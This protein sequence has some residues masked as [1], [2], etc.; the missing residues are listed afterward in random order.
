MRKKFYT[1]FF[2]IFSVTFNYAFAANCSRVDSG[3]NYWYSCDGTQVTQTARTI[4]G[5]S[6]TNFT[7]V[8]TT[9]TW[10]FHDGYNNKNIF[11]SIIND[12]L[13]GYD[14]FKAAGSPSS[15]ID[16][17]LIINQGVS[18]SSTSTSQSAIYA[19]KNLPSGSNFILINKGNIFGACGTGGGG[20]SWQSYPG[21]FRTGGNGGN[22]GNAINLFASS[23]I[24]NFGKI[25]SGGGGGGGGGTGGSYTCGGEFGYV[26]WALGGTG[27]N[28]GSCYSGIDDP[29]DSPGA[30]GIGGGC[31]P[32]P[33]SGRP[34]GAGGSSYYGRSGS[35]GLNGIGQNCGS[36]NMYWC[37]YTTYGLG[38]AGG[39]AGLSIKTNSFPTCIGGLQ[40]EVKGSVSGSY[41][42][43]CTIDPGVLKPPS[44]SLYTSPSLV[45]WGSNSTINWTSS[46]SLYCEATND[47]SGTKSTSGQENTGAIKKAKTYDISCLG[48]TGQIISAT[49]SVDFMCPNGYWESSIQNVWVG[50]EL[51][52][53][54][55]DNDY[56]G[57]D[58]NTGEQCVYCS[59]YESQDLGQC[60]DINPTFYSDNYVSS[61][62]VC[63]EE[64][65]YLYWEIYDNNYNY[66]PN[67]KLNNCRIEDENTGFLFTVSESYGYTTTNPAWGNNTYRLICDNA[68][69][70]PSVS[71]ILNPINGSMKNLKIND[72]TCNSINLS[73]DKV[74]CSSQYIL[75]R[76][77]YGDYD[78]TSNTSYTDSSDILEGTSYQYQVRACNSNGVCTDSLSVS[79][80]TP[81]CAGN[82]TINSTSTCIAT[83]NNGLN[84]KK[85]YVNKQMQW[86][87]TSTSVNIPPY[88]TTTWSG[89]DIQSTPQRASTILN[90]IYT[91]V[92][93]KTITATSTWIENGIQKTVTCSTSTNVILGGDSIIEI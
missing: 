62:Y 33:M 49:T 43:N 31:Y 32:S 53:P 72:L 17:V 78:S 27:G 52:N 67:E 51:C 77:G 22:G 10:F 84:N 82:N 16:V 2:I 87:A 80:T 5:D 66:V 68:V 81:L 46:N 36:T 25:Y 57:Y 18:I 41:T 75:N 48:Y 1:T 83:Q 39:A 70:T 89:R 56:D 69:N 24:Y 34:G 38:G 9:T 54:C 40:G 21:P 60:V 4:A 93:L 59:V 23:S 47:W 74:D 79:T 19:S 61:A 91:T 63:D 76:S 29:G 88:A 28:G 42:T 37:N 13:Q 15:S 35:V 26:S 30:P 58:D 45:N 8:S 6:I 50:E 85:I 73:W 90:K 3:G 14:L 64:I 65:N 92:G 55:E 44:V 20:G 11:T 7:N 86:E 71:F 12:D